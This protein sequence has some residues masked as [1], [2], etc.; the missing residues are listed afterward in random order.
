MLG[1]ELRLLRADDLAAELS[2]EDIRLF[3]DEVRL[4]TAATVLGMALGIWLFGIAADRFGRKPA[5]LVYQA[6]AVVMVSSTRI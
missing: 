5:F 4:W 2:V 6:G 1:A 3:A